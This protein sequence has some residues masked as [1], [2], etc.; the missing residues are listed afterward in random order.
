M[1]ILYV[2]IYSYPKDELKH[3]SIPLDGSDYE[4]AYGSIS[5]DDPYLRFQCYF[6]MLIGDESIMLTKQ[7]D[8]CAWKVS[9]V[10]SVTNPNLGNASHINYNTLF[11][12]KKSGDEK[13]INYLL[14]CNLTEDEAFK[15]KQFY[16]NDC[17]S[18]LCL[19]H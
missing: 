12:L 1:E 2:G 7:K 8:L 19:D 16:L 13:D 10:F 15:L 5:H 17:E 3:G 14:F 4:H 6:K 11:S 18:S 9:D